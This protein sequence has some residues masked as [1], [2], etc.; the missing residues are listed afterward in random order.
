MVSNERNTDSMD[1]KVFIIADEG[2]DGETRY[3]ELK[4]V[5]RVTCDNLI[6]E[7]SPHADYNPVSPTISFTL[8]QPSR[9]E[10]KVS[11]TKHGRS[12]KQIKKDRKRNKNNR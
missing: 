6:M 12:R 4:G 3:E 2:P 1:L 10:N 5:S 9:G 11:S 8:K 7:N